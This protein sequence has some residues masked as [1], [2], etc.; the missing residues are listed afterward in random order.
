MINLNTGLSITI[1][2]LFFIVIMVGYVYV[3]ES[4]RT[5]EEAKDAI[6]I[7]NKTQAE[8]LEQWKA[9]QVIDNVRFNKTLQGLEETYDLILGNQKLIIN[10]SGLGSHSVQTNLNLTKFNRA[11]LVD[12]NHK[13]SEILRL[14]NKTN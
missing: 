5:S 6:K 9:K 8:F 12:T 4:R 1:L 14:L 2:I 10:L 13:V 3:D 11:S 7:V